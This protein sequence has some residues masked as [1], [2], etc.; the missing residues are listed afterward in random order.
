MWGV[1]S[2]DFVTSTGSQ[3]WF[4]RFDLAPSVVGLGTLALG[5]ARAGDEPF[6]LDEAVSALVV[7]RPLVGLTHVLYDQEA[8]MTS[9]YIGLWAWAQIFP[10]DMGL[11]MFSVLGGAVT[12]ALLFV[13]ATRW[14]GRTTGWLAALFLVT[15]PFFLRYLTEVRTY[16]WTMAAVVAAVVF[17]DRA[18]QSQRRID[19]GAAG[20]AIG[21]GIASHLLFVFLPVILIGSAVACGL[22]LRCSRLVLLVSIA[23]IVV[24]P[25]VPSL[26][27]R[28]SQLDWLG[29]QTRAVYL[30]Q[31]LDFTGG[32]IRLSVLVVGL[33]LAVLSV[34]DDNSR[35]WPVLACA[36]PA[37]LIPSL[38][39]LASA[40]KFLFLSRYLAPAFPVLVLGAAAGYGFAIGRLANHHRSLAAAT[41]LA[42]T[43][44]IP[45]LVASPLDDKARGRGVAEA[46]EFVTQRL[47]PSEL[48]LI[49]HHRAVVM[50]HL[51][52]R[53]AV[54]PGALPPRSNQLEL[55]SRPIQDYISQLDSASTIYIIYWEGWPVEPQ[56]QRL[57]DTRTLKEVAHF[58]TTSVLVLG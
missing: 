13:L 40:F 56:A 28:R 14:F 55:P 29:P 4:Q 11:R 5:A 51:G 31:T 27:S 49:E 57:V 15:N 36:M 39:L 37:M 44:A 23:V 22:R 9:Y 38:T 48:I 3:P 45:F 16:S 18:F 26:L 32:R 2:T 34:R 21:M 25:A 8:G 7:R 35:S 30:Q 1:E 10:S 24:L 12:A 41:L 47:Q 54:D 20:V 46:V 52:Y 43:A 19:S 50:H 17:V 42:L 6:W 33:L 58:G 53:P